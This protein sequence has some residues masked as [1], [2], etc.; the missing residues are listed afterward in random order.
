[1]SVSLNLIET[2]ICPVGRNGA[3]KKF[4][5]QLQKT[6]VY[7]CKCGLRFIDPSLDEKSM[8]EIYSSSEC[9][10]ELNP[11]LQ[12]YYEYETLNTESAT[13]RDYTKALAQ[14]SLQVR[15]EICLKSDAEQAG[16]WN[17]PG[18]MGGTCAE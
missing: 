8:T 17:L 9:L 3:A 1:M 10:R 7:R 11:A 18:K 16:F 5:F 13:F 6:R 4:L 14:V 15:G 2:K 12:S